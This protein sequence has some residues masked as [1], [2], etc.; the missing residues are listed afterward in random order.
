LAIKATYRGDSSAIATVLVV[1]RD[2]DNKL[3]A[4]QKQAVTFTSAGSEVQLV[5][6]IF[7]KDEVKLWWPTGYGEQ[8]RYV[9][10]VTL[11]A[12]VSLPYMRVNVSLT[13][14]GLEHSRQ[15][16]QNLRVSFC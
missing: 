14:A 3:V 11:L 15:A 6:W 5:K 1:L 12:E 10:E 7:D 16:K 9:V 4:E 13:R 2:P 8:A